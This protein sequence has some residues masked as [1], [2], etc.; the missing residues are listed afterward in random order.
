MSPLLLAAVGAAG[1]GELPVSA[2]GDL[3]SFAIVSFPYEHSL[4]DDEVYG[5]A[6]EDVRLRLRL[7]LPA[8]WRIEGHHAVS[9]VVGSTTGFGATGAG[10][11]TSAPQLVD[12]D[13][14]VDGS[15]LRGR[16]DRLFVQGELGPVTVA[17]G[18]QPISFGTGLA[19]TPLDLVSPFSP[20][21]IDSEYKPGVDA[22]RVSAYGGIVFQQELAA[23]WVGDC[24]VTGGCEVGLDDLSLASWSRVTIGV[25]DLALFL[26][27]VHADEVVGL[28][29]ASGVGPVGLHGDAS[30]TLPADPEVEDPFVRA[31]VG[32]DG[33]VTTTTSLGLELYVQT[34]GATDPADYLTVALDDRHRRG[35]LWAM[36]RSYA[37]VTAGQEIVPTLQSSLA[38]LANLEDPSVLLVPGLAWS[39]AENVDVSGGAW[40]GLG[41]RPDGHDVKSEFGILPASVYV[42]MAVVR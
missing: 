40:I 29:L 7:D 15:V 38:V 34:L 23:A 13:W 8:D 39:A 22:V 20:A 3:K 30:F 14:E 18:R 10:V 12:L 1:A 4:L 33:R 26:G 24:V 19:F 11:A 25:T 35:E 27:E 16:T 5:Q 2:H 36:G 17:L 21:T 31:V 37:A 32:A 41:A 9:V 6:I 28:S 42:R